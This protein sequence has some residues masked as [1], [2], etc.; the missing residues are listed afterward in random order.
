VNYALLFGPN[1]TFLR[2]AAF[3]QATIPIFGMLFAQLDVAGRA[4]AM[5]ET[6]GPL[7]ALAGVP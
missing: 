3:L 2:V 1:F 4:A 5:A 6:G 7:I